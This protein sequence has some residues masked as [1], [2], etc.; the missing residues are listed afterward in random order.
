MHVPCESRASP[1][2][3][4]AQ[5]RVNSPKLYLIGTLLAFERPPCACIVNSEGMSIVSSRF[6]RHTKALETI[7]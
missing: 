6:A 3:S 5:A 2:I 4:L 1:A 7:S